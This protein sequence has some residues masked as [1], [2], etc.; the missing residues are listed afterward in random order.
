ML[1]FLLISLPTVIL[2]LFIPIGHIL[3]AG[4]A[5]LAGHRW[6]YKLDWPR[7]R[8]LLGSLYAGLA[9]G[10]GLQF[11]V[12]YA[13][14]GNWLAMVLAP[15]YT[16]PCA[17]GLYM[18]LSEPFS[19]GAGQPARELPTFM[20]NKLPVPALRPDGKIDLH[21][22]DNTQAPNAF[23]T[24]MW[25]EIGMGGPSYGEII[26]ANGCAFASM[27][28]EVYLL[29]EGRYAWLS[30]AGCEEGSLLVDLQ[31]RRCYQLLGPMPDEESLP[32]RLAEARELPMAQDDGWWVL[33]YPEREPFPD[34]AETR[35]AS[36]GG[37]H[38]V[39]LLPDTRGMLRNPFQRYGHAHYQVSI[40][41]EVFGE[42]VRMLPR[43]QWID[44]P[45]APEDDDNWRRWEGC[46]LILNDELL[47]FCSLRT[48]F[49][50]DAATRVALGHCDPST[51]LHFEEMTSD[52]PG[53]LVATACAMPRNTYPDEAESYSFS[54]VF[55]HDD[56]EAS[57]WDAEGREHE[58]LRPRATRYYLY[59][60]DL[61][62]LSYL[63]QLR[64][65]ADV[66]LI[67]RARPENTARFFHD[68]GNGPHAEAWHGYRLQTSCGVDPGLV[69]HEAIWSDCGRYLAVLGF[70]H[71]PEVPHEIR[72]IDFD[73][74]TLRRLPGNY[75]LPSFNWFDAQ[76]L[77]FS[78]IIGVKE[79][80]RLPGLPMRWEQH[81]FRLDDGTADAAPY[82]LL[83]AGIEARR[84]R[85]KA[86]QAKRIKP[87]Q[88]DHS[89]VHLINQHC[90][91]FAP[92][93]I[94]PVLQPP[95]NQVRSA[96]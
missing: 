74:S 62:K 86:L 8:R 92:D 41:G 61:S 21:R 56:Y 4:A 25:G 47:D 20:I 28:D 72:I 27:L 73:T 22:P 34:F 16:W 43:A 66:E 53:Q 44:A 11:I 33:D 52:A 45:H 51:W 30:P 1:R 23:E 10:L 88:D 57:W 90:I 46:Y 78:H 40:D 48:H 89:S 70:A 9:L 71:A 5:V 18:L 54:Y 2:A 67:N 15:I 75:A 42:P 91:L 80:C 65:S 64:L 14:A 69:A 39:S 93:F 37:H 94:A 35:I 7:Y 95:A 77:D 6:C 68:F 60:I 81:D 63:G 50:T 12:D 84:E 29:G 19:T 3:L 83:I 32:R 82:D 24:F 58:E 87:G 31:A 26:F 76:K 13:V 59:R 36:S 96:Q 85:L 79:D 49:S 38:V 55:P 17:W